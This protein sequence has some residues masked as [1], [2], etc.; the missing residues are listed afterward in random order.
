MRMDVS[1]NGTIT[2]LYGRNR[3]SKPVIIITSATAGWST[4][5]PTP[6]PYLRFSGT[7]LAS[8]TKV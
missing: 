4:V 5:A 2:F 6:P 1:K 8:Q 7:T 3:I